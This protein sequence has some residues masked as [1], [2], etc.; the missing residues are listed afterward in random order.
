MKAYFGLLF[1]AWLRNSF[2]GWRTGG[3]WQKKW[4]LL[5]FHVCGW[6]QRGNLAIHKNVTCRIV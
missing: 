5:H 4:S 1:L 3:R 6:G 2:P